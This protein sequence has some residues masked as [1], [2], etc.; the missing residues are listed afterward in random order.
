MV[1]INVACFLDFSAAAEGISNVVSLHIDYLYIDFYA[2]KGKSLLHNL[3][4]ENILD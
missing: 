3:L 1:G 2:I 4:R